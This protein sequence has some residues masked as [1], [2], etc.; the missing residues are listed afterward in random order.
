MKRTIVAGGLVCVLATA[1]GGPSSPTTPSLSGSSGAS[2]AATA[3]TAQT[4]G[5]SIF[6]GGSTDLAV[7]LQSSSDPACFSAARLRARTVVANAIAPGAPGLLTANVIGS[8]VTLTWTAPSSGDVVLSYILEA[9]STSGA[10]NLANIATNST[11]TTFSASGIGAGTYFVRVRAQNASGVSPASNEVVV[12]VTAVGCT[13]APGAPGGLNGTVFGGTVTLTWNAPVGGCAPSSYVLQAGSGSG[14]SNL[15]NFNTGSVLTIYIANVAAGTYFVR[16]TAANGTGQSAPSNEIAVTISA[17]AATYTGPFTGQLNLTVI[18]GLTGPG[19]PTT[20]HETTAINGTLKIT[21]QQ[22]SD[23]TVSG[24]A[25]TAGV[26]TLITPSCSDSNVSVNSPFVWNGLPVTGTTASLAFNG[27][28]TATG[29]DANDIVTNSLAFSG[30]LTS[31]VI[32][33]TLSYVKTG[34]NPNTRADGSVT[35][36]VTLR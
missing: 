23:G 24:T 28:T 9:G 3:A 2:S 15:A 21:L 16:V 29:Q 18:S 13:S 6:G 34:R 25:D 33:G 8:S 5:D 4:P 26:A 14:L 11:A 7:C 30:T 17:G 35:F 36:P 20:C 1:C 32:S 19:P 12:V 27:Q 10:A 22:R 31:G